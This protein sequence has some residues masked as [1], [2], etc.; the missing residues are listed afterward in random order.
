ME[1]VEANPGKVRFVLERFRPGVE[2]A[3]EFQAALSHRRA[4]LP[5][6]DGL[7]VE[8]EE[9]AFAPDLAGGDPVGREAEHLGLDAE[10]EL[11][12]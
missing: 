6:A 2:A 3:Q 11:S 1:E 4:I 7:L 5:I 8:P 9:D 12:L 10:V